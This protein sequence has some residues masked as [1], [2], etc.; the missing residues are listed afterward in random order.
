M[1][2]KWR[3]GER[4]GTPSSISIELIGK[5]IELVGYEV[6]EKSHPR[7]RSNTPQQMTKTKKVTL[8]VKKHA[9]FLLNNFVNITRSSRKNVSNE[10]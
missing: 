8:V 3:L 9:F 4:N 2:T 6:D 10:I 5:T 7:Y 1:P